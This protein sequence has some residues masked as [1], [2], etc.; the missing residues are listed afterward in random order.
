MNHG[1]APCGL[2]KL[3]CS[4]C[5]LKKSHHRCM[6]VTWQHHLTDE[7]E[8]GLGDAGLVADQFASHRPKR[9]VYLWKISIYHRYTIDIPKKSPING[10]VKKGAN[11]HR[12]PCS[13]AK[14]GGFA[15]K[16]SLQ[17][18]HGSHANQVPDEPIMISG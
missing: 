12:K 14:N 15:L 2:I 8:V 11:R 13:N 18:I 10:W 17:P 1:V 7:K 16:C 4:S 5:V 9:M 6:A 3:R